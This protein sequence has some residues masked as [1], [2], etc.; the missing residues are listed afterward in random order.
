MNDDIQETV[1]SSVRT[2]GDNDKI[3]TAKIDVDI[4]E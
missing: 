4:I 1:I 2:G 3:A